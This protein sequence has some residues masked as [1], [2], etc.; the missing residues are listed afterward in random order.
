MKDH[1]QRVPRVLLAPHRARWEG[2]VIGEGPR[3]LVGQNRALS[4]ADARGENWEAPRA[5]AAPDDER[6]A[7]EVIGEGPRARVA[8][9]QERSAAELVAGAAGL[10]GSLVALFDALALAADPLPN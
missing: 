1:S 10:L 8:P 9:H 5:L 3:A 4:K 2:E 7:R 6:S